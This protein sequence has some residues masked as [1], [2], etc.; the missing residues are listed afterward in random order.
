LTTTQVVKQLS[1][2]QS[3]L[4]DWTREISAKVNCYQSGRWCAGGH[5][6]QA[7]TKIWRRDPQKLVSSLF[8]AIVGE[9]S[10]DLSY[11]LDCPASQGREWLGLRSR[12][13][14]SAHGAFS[15]RRMPVG[16]G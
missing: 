4:P 16:R 3:W 12:T 15:T 14:I 7:A 13:T 10:S 1:T 2:G 9:A 8:L 6:N 5:V 11:G